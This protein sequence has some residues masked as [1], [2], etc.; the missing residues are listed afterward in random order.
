MKDNR[1][2]RAVPAARSGALAI[3]FSLFASGAALSHAYL[4][5]DETKA[6]AAYEAIV[7][8][9]HGCD[10]LP[11]D[12]VLI[13]VP[14]NMIVLEAPEAE[15]WT[16]SATTQKL[17]EPV[18]VNGAMVEESIVA[19]KW[20]GGS[21]PHD[22]VGQVRFAGQILD[23]LEPGTELH[24]MVVQQCE[25]KAVRWIEIRKEGQEM[26]D[27]E[28]PAPFLTIIDEREKSVAGDPAKMDHGN[29]ANHAN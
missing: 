6:G 29:H 13:K 4:E 23:G 8:L 26:S 24:F 17:A 18:S 27:M 3:C 25:D 2:R 9:P 15:G 19:L 5:T 1:H 21:I 16:V 10:G 22:D 28:A 7:N 12:T 11:T 14:E 20:T